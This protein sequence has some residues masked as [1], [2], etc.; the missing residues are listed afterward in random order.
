MIGLK[1][2]KV[3]SGTLLG[4]GEEKLE[5]L[6]P[7][8]DSETALDVQIWE[9]LEDPL[10]EMSQLEI[11]ESAFAD[12]PVKLKAAL[13]YKFP[14]PSHLARYGSWLSRFLLT[15]QYNHRHRLLVF[16]LPVLLRLPE[17]GAEARATASMLVD[18]KGV[19]VPKDSR[20]DTDV[21][22]EMGGAPY[23]VR[24]CEHD[25]TVRRRYRQRRDYGPAEMQLLLHDVKFA[26]RSRRATT[27]AATR[28]ERESKIISADDV[29]HFLNELIDDT[30]TSETK[31]YEHNRYNRRGRGWR[32]WETGSLGRVLHHFELAFGRHKYRLHP[33]YAA[34]MKKVLLDKKASLKRIHEQDERMARWVE[35]E[36]RSPTCRQVLKGKLKTYRHFDLLGKGPFDRASAKHDKAIEASLAAVGDDDA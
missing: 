16:E 14:L 21:L 35:Y 10:K 13:A 36:L 30:P 25:T 22:V 32:T 6:F 11:H 20:I 15:K 34:F 8:P 31:V 33:A 3:Y 29:R 24:F 2:T 9:E 19:L 23:E 5:K 26:V 27:A 17:S 12:D 4:K 28:V 1:R 18:C 7:L